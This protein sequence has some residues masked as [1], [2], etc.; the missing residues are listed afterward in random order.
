MPV[1]RLRLSYSIRI[2]ALVATGGF[3]SAF[4]CLAR[5][6]HADNGPRPNE[7]ESYKTWAVYNGSSANIKYSA[8]DQITPSNIKHLQ[9]A[10]TYSSTQASSANRTDMKTNPLIV[11]GTLFG[12]NPELKL[13]ALDAATGKEKWVYDP[14]HVPLKGKNIGRGDFAT[15]TKISRGLAY[16]RGSASDQR[17]IYAPGGGHALYCVDA[18]TGKLITSFGDHGI[19]DLHDNLDEVLADP[20][21]LYVSMT[22]PGII[23]KDLIIVGLRLSEGAQTPPG[24]IRAYDVH[25]GKLRWTFHTVPHPGELGYETYQNKDAYKYVGA[26]NP[27]GGFS[28]DEKRGIVFA[29][30]GSPTPDFYG[31]YRKGYDLFGDST[32]AINANTGKLIWYFQEVHHDLWDRDNPCPPIL[33]T[34]TQNGKKRD[35][36]V[37]TTKMGYIFMF[38]RVTGEPIHSIHEIPVPQTKLKGEYTAPTQPVP[39]FFQ[40][41]SRTD[42][43]EADLFKDG[44]SEESYQD[45]LKRFRALETDNMWNPP[46]TKGT[47]QNPGLNGGGEWGGPA[48]DPA[49]EI[50]YINGNNSPFVIGP[51]TEVNND[52]EGTHLHGTNLQV[53]KTL[54]ERN[55]SRCHGVDRRAGQTNPAL[56]TYPSLA[57]IQL[58]EGSVESLIAT[59]RGTMPDFSYLSDAERTAIASYVL[60]LKSK[61][62]E[63]FADSGQSDIPEYY[64]VPYKGIITKFLTQEGYP[65]IKPP[66]GQLTAINLNTGKVIWTQTIGDYPE[67]KAKGIHAGSENFG[68]PVVTAGG[69]AFIAATR[70]E[71]IRGFNK[72]TGE[73]LWEA[74]LPAA[75]I[76]TPAVYQVNGKEYVVIACGGGGKQLTRSGD[77]YVAFAL[78]DTDLSP[79]KNR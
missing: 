18:I 27:W 13:F 73:L 17:I 39:T 40:P 76:A 63:M 59:G 23:Y 58:P 74:D 8:L 69:V 64:R 57:G 68:A 50:L 15:S 16:Y 9:V 36:A 24:N 28:L 46:S 10:W 32:L 77:K 79:T 22:S 49:T 14:V 47:I 44:I 78:P 26:N 75:G 29:G 2:V 1:S 55:C 3:L 4:F 38:D 60:D 61:Q 70:D 41:F 20:N 52:H 56:A 25:T 11:D 45:L 71:N 67:L 72:S 65:G 21:D 66:W 54:Y 5:S 7:Q 33:A 42:L 30:T 19:V 62:N 35:V 6:S 34:I 37:Q 48:F 51:R 31:G 53:G 43:T 12:L